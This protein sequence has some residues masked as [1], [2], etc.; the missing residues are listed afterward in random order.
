MTIDEIIKLIPAGKRDAAIAYLEGL[1]HGLK[2]VE[3]EARKT[4]DSDRGK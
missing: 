2:I 1:V 4:N 3:Q